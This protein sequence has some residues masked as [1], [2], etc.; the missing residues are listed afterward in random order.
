M[1]LAQPE[2][3]EVSALAKVWAQYRKVPLADGAIHARQCWGILAEG[4]DEAAAEE[5]LSQL[6]SAQLQGTRIS[7]D[8]LVSPA[9]PQVIR[10]LEVKGDDLA[11]IISSIAREDIAVSDLSV[12]AAA[13]FQ[14]TSTKKVQVEKGPTAGQKMLNAGILIATGIPFKLGGPKRVETKSESHSELSC[15]L[16]LCS[17]GGAR[18]WRIN[19]QSFDYSFLKERKTYS[20]LSNFKQLVSDMVMRTPQALRNHGTRLLLTGGEMRLMGYTSLQD[21]DREISWLLT[22]ASLPKG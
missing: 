4:L 21:L 6:H 3:Y 1:I 17:V 15:Y 12:V 20:I 7:A 5:L 18:R 16:D 10:R 2:A 14:E 22:L 19:G 9:P 8:R 13:L 11:A